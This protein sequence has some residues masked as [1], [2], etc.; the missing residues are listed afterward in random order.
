MQHTKN[1]L[2]WGFPSEKNHSQ[3]LYYHSWF[4]N[5]LFMLGFQGHNDEHEGDLGKNKEI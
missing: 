1:G 2:D 5:W 4:S 3:M